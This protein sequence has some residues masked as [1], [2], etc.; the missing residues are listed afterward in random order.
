MARS[1]AGHF[2][3]AAIAVWRAAAR[4]SSQQR[5]RCEKTFFADARYPAAA[6]VQVERL[7]GA[8]HLLEVK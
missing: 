7:Y 6:W 2:A 4:T 1:D 5:N 8:G 3:A